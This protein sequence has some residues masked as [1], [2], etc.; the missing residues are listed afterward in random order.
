MSN[1]DTIINVT[2]QIRNARQIMTEIQCSFFERYA[3]TS[4]TTTEDH[5]EV[6]TYDFNTAHVY[7]DILEDI[8]ARITDLCK[9]GCENNE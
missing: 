3:T 6:S 2:R 5:I 1:S 9:K 7:A 8:L 4:H